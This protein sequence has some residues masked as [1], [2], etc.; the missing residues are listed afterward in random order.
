MANTGM[1]LDAS[2]WTAALEKLG[3]PLRVSLARSMA[4]AGGKVLRD[5]AKQ[6]APVESGKLREAIYLAFKDGMSTDAQVV[7]SV[8]WSPKKAPHGHLI[9][10]GHWRYNKIINGYP[11]KSLINGKKRGNGPQDHGGPGALQTPI[12]TPAKPFLRPAY[13]VAKDHARKAMIDRGRER[14]PELLAEIANGT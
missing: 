5:E 12:W 10:F 9:E 13:D 7:Y 3:G 14:L 4:V 8:T 11:Q 6:Q 2:E 1:K